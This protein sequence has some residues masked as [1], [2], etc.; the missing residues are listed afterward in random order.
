MIPQGTYAAE[1]YAATVWEA[2]SGALMVTFNFKLLD[3][4]WEQQRPPNG[5]L[6]LVNKAGAVSEIT[7]ADLRKAWP[8][9]DGGDPFWFQDP[10][11]LAG[12]T[13]EIVVEPRSFTG[14]DGKE[15]TSMDVKY[16]NAPG[17]NQPT[18]ADRSA[19]LKKYGAR[20]RAVAG[21]TTLPLKPTPTPAVPP[22]APAVPP[23]AEPP[24]TEDD[25]PFNLE[26]PP[27]EPPPPPKPSG[28]VATMNDCWAACC[29]AG[30]K[31]GMDQAE[32]QQHWYDA[33]ARLFPG[34]SN[35]DFTPHDWGVVRGAFTGNKPF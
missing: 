14:R 24:D 27:D 34:K 6:C 12:V 4:G 1:A 13:V 15:H 26:S 23:T 29:T 2:D 28:P 19:V 32:T 31:A 9:W 10:K 21:G 30:K 22:T 3:P 25:V 20:F 5:S 7:I 35:S 8:A 17:G 33:L 11:N 16:I 18:A